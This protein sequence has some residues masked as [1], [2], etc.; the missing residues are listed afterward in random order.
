MNIFFHELQAYRKSTIIWIVTLSTLAVVFLSMFPAFTKDVDTAQKILAH[1]PQAVRAALDISLKNFFTVYGFFAYL[2][3]FVSLAG[4]VQ[5]MN[6]G[7][8]L[9]SKEDSGK[10]AD[11]SLTK[12]ISRA[13]VI[14]SKLFAAVCLLVVTNAVFSLVAVF[15]ARTVVVG[16]FS[17]KT[18]LL[19]SS[20]LLFIQM[21]FLAIGFLMSVTIPKIKSVISVTL[22]T[23][24]TFFIIGTLGAILGNDKVRY[25]TPFK[26]YDPN[27]VMAHGTYE[28]K[29][30]VL[31]L[32]LLTVA[33]IVTYI[34]YI[35]KDIRAAS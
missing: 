2:F 3:T 6:L 24:F 28:L 8:G 29:F 15:V 19:I 16:H 34:V 14:T 10:T 11:F 31:E 27:Y 23:V 4:A 1:L 35:R 12:P 25:I 21:M 7:V 5:A 26:F 20:I 33:I 18:F 9:I 32:L 13:Q 22:P 17:A 30:L